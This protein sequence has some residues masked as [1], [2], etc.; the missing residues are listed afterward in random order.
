[1]SL[2][3][4]TQILHASALRSYNDY[5]LLRRFRIQNVVQ[6]SACDDL[7]GRFLW[8][9]DQLNSVLAFRRKEQILARTDERSAGRPDRSA[10]FSDHC[11]GLPVP[12]LVQSRFRTLRICL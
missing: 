3:H 10:R 2:Q 9:A 11:I 8:W 4:A 5:I 1:M 6:G 7:V 12:W